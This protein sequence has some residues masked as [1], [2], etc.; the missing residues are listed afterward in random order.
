MIEG[1]EKKNR[2]FR[3]DSMD[4]RV[5]SPFL[6]RSR[7]VFHSTVNGHDD[8]A[9][10]VETA[11]IREEKKKKKVAMKCAL[12]TSGIGIC[13]EYV[14]CGDLEPRNWHEW[15]KKKSISVPV[16]CQ[17]LDEQVILPS[18]FHRD[19]FDRT[20]PLFPPP[21]LLFIYLLNSY[22]FISFLNIGYDFSR[23]I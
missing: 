16:G 19:S 22:V 15:K 6:S 11:I 1:R 23:C 10:G 8:V 9:S 13:P 3:H 17:S 7:L 5:I 14:R 20:I 12:F 21:Y 2:N 4:S 18:N